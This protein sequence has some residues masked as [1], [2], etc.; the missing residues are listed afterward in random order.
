M[1][2]KDTYW[3]MLIAAGLVLAALAYGGCAGRDPVND[4]LD[5]GGSLTR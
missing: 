3:R 2:K 1:A 5:P 4:D